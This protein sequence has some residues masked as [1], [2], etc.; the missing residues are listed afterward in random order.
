MRDP[1]VSV[2][3]P[4]YNRAHCLG[5]AIDSVLAQNFQDYELIVVDDGSTDET[6]G[7]MKAYD[8][9][10]KL[11]RQNNSGV[12]SARNAGI[13]AAG[14]EW[15]AFLDSDDTWEPDKLKVQVDD[16]QASPGAVAHMVDATIVVSDHEH[17]SLFELR[18]I[19]EDFLRRP[20]RERPLCD[21]LKVQF[22]TSTWIVHR[23]AIKSAGY[24]DPG[25]KI[26][27]D[28]DLLTRVAVEGAFIINGYQGVN[29]RRV[30]GSIS[31]SDTH[32][33]NMLQSLLNLLQTYIHLKNDPRLTAE[34]RKCVSRLIG[35]LQCEISTQ[36]RSQR[37]ISA[38]LVALL[39]SVAAE[40]G[41]RSVARMFVHAVGAREFIDRLMHWRKKP[42]FRRQ[43]LGGEVGR[44]GR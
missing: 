23:K 24:F 35:G 7:I 2:V 10:V 28:Y 3:I 27:E 32:S 39:Q 21:V 29:M 34:E 33:E 40:P 13:R 1:I 9:R 14:G 44:I 20:F 31:L 11:I 5:D 43:E 19:Q 22:F 42:G 17:I 6:C 25:M 26:Y 8:G 30:G 12:S 38:A 41:L 16:L 4:T 15:I 36:H 18:G 37:N